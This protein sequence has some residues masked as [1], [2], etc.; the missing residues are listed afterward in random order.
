MKA[1]VIIVL[2]LIALGALMS[3]VDPRLNFPVISQAVCSL[4]GDTWYSGGIL[5]QPGCYVPQ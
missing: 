2:A 1:A 5:G 4:K 3:A